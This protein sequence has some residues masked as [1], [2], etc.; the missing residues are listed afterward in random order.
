MMITLNH[1]HTK[2]K[3]ENFSNSLKRNALIL[4]VVDQC[5]IIVIFIIMLEYNS[6]NL[7]K[8]ITWKGHQRISPPMFEH[9]MA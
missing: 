6:R 4:S 9:L 1:Q 2:K 7:L 3:L 5:I 8:K